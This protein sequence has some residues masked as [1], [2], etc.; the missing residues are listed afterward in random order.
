MNITTCSCKNHD[1][2]A[3][4]SE[5][6]MLNVKVKSEEGYDTDGSY[7]DTKLK[8]K[9][10]NNGKYEWGF[11]LTDFNDEYD[12]DYDENDNTGALKF[13]ELLDRFKLNLCTESDGSFRWSN[14]DASLVLITGHNPITGEYFR[15]SFKEKERKGYAGYVG[16]TC[17]SSIVLDNFVLEFRDKAGYIK[18][19]SRNRRNYI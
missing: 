10:R 2:I 3:S 16:V 4:R 19:E 13:Q 6:G 15:N 11:D 9:Q 1:N 18:D 7:E 17:N 5:Q 12:D 8:I 14:K